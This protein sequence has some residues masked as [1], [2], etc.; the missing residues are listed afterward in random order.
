LLAGR[1]AASG[2][3]LE[4]APVAA[5]A[6]RM[7]QTEQPDAS[8]GGMEAVKAAIARWAATG[9]VPLYEAML[10][11]PGPPLPT[12]EEGKAFIEAFRAQLRKK[13]LPDG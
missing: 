4:M 2:R 6:V 3:V 10:T 1:E 7:D 12:A 13:G 5:H 11:D 9:I 8:P